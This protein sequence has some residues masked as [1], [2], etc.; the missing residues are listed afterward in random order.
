CSLEND[1]VIGPRV[2]FR[3]GVV[4]HSRTRIWPEVVV[5][6]GTVVKEHLL[7]DEYAVKC[8]GS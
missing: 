8:E 7:N 4:V 5:P 6:D 1:T 3:N 2:V